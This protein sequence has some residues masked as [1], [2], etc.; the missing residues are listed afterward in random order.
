MQF[1]KKTRKLKN[2]ARKQDKI[3]NMIHFDDFI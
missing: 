3:K 2:A 1:K